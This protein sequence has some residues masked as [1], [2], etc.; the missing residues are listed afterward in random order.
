MARVP[1]NSD[2]LQWALDRSGVPR[3]DLEKKFP[4]LSE[5]ESGEV[6]PTYKQVK[7]LARAI[8]VP[9][10]YLFM[11]EPPSESIPIQ[12]F[13]T[14][15]G[16]TPT[17]PSPNLIDTI[18]MCQDRQ[19]WYRDY[20]SANDMPRLPFVGSAELGD[21]PESTAAKM[22]EAIGFSVE[23]Q[24]KCG[25][26]SAARRDLILK[27]EDSGVLVMIN[28]IVGNNTRRTLNVDE[29]RGFA[30][31]DQIAPLIF[32]NGRDG[33][34]A[35]MFTLAHELAHIWLGTSALSKAGIRM[36]GQFPREEVWCNSV[37]AEF[38]VPMKAIKNEFHAADD[39][40]RELE[41]LSSIFN[42]SKLVVLRRLVD[43]KL[44]VR[45]E[46][47]SEWK[48]E[49]SA[50]QAKKEEEEKKGGKKGGNF[51]NSFPYRVSRTFAKALISSAVG[52]ETLH[53]DAAR[54]LCLSSVGKMMK[55]GRSL[56]VV[57]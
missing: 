38:L 28:G 43:A 10:G 55:S 41:R 48:A 12:D 8:Y 16:R 35:Q 25:D 46:F 24:R 11:S 50:I 33:I 29:F 52:G 22:R 56:G 9:F 42:V 54:L 45:S 51:R 47:E 15:K 44:M 27:I 19:E 13:R 53:R 39:T 7:S 5:W 31:S 4:K 49:M 57:R 3:D 21:S 1:V 32:V 26:A 34:S 37:A 18:Y 30:L 2:V 14:L 17:R 23:E 40:H 20:A 6:L 36:D